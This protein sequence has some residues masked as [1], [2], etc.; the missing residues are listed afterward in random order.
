MD[1]AIQKILCDKSKRKSNRRSS[2]AYNETFK[3]IDM[4]NP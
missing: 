1:E 3:M 2:F 4:T